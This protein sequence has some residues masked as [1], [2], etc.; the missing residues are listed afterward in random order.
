MTHRARVTA[1]ESR[2]ASAGGKHLGLVPSRFE[3]ALNRISNSPI[4][5]DRYDDVCRMR[6][7]GRSFAHE[8]V[9]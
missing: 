5:V 6:H 9:G 2:N 3:D 1:P 4:V 8:T 7:Q